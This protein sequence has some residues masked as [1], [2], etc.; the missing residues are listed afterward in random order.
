MR[1]NSC[2][3]AWTYFMKEKVHEVKCPN[4]KKKVCAKGQLVLINNKLLK[5]VEDAMQFCNKL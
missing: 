4:C 1:C 5:E 3:Y 2:G